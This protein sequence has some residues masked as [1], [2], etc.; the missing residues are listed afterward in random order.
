MGKACLQTLKDILQYK[1]GAEKC[2]VL[3][4]EIENA[5]VLDCR[6]DWTPSQ[7][8]KKTLNNWI[9]T[10]A[11]GMHSSIYQKRPIYFP[12][13]SAKKSFFL[14]VNIHQWN[15]GTLNSIL[16][17]YLNPDISLLENR[18]KRHREV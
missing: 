18:I 4:E 12:L 16:A 2:A 8:S 14:Y 9:R 15:E 11:F 10:A 6:T 7:R 13:V 3:W 17:N 5:L 1:W